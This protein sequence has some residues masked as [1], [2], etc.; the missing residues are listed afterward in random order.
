[1]ILNKLRN[2]LLNPDAP[3]DN[4]GGSNDTP[5]NTNTGGS[6]APTIPLPPH[7]KDVVMDAD[8]DSFNSGSDEDAPEIK[9]I[10]EVKGIEIIAPKTTTVK[11]KDSDEPPFAPVVTKPELGKLPGDLEVT[12]AALPKKTNKETPNTPANKDIKTERD[13]SIFDESERALFKATSNEVFNHLKDVLPKLREKAK[14]ADTLEK[15]LKDSGKY[16][17]PE[18]FNHPRAFTLHPEYNAITEKRDMLSNESNF[19][20][21][22]LINVKNGQPYRILRGYDSRTGNPVYSDPIEI[23]DANKASVE[24]EL[25]GVVNEAQ[26]VINNLNADASMFEKGFSDNY[27]EQAKYFDMILEQKAPWVKDSKDTRHEYVNA[28]MSAIPDTFR[29]HPSTKVA[30]VLYAII[31]HGIKEMR[32]LQDKLAQLEGIKTITQN[33]EEATPSNSSSGAS[34]SVGAVPASRNGPRYN[35][36]GRLINTKPMTGTISLEDIE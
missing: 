3:L 10:K 36:Q 18:W 12:P 13:Y 9:A 1:M 2:I 24:M 17:P 4:D 8:E 7:L 11:T 20:K 29:G 22:Q 19:Y 34:K 14:N 31:Q 6:A 5:V 16:I 33:T 27:R 30:G 28:F 26:N 32:T 21:Q 25:H 35:N 15:Q 23:N